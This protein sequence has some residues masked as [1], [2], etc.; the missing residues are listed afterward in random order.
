MLDQVTTAL[1]DLVAFS[2]ANEPQLMPY[3]TYVNDDGTQ[4]T[5]FRHAVR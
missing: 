5:V 3:G 4:M 2:E 1:G